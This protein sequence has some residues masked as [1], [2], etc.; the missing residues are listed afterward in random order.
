MLAS[1]LPDP[2]LG[3]VVLL[4]QKGDR[5][6]DEVAPEEARWLMADPFQVGPVRTAPPARG[7]ATAALRAAS[8]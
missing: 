3:P 2:E 7:P 4:A 1:M 8:R 5:R 6:P